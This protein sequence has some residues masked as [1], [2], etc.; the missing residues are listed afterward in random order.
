MPWLQG[1][2]DVPAS[3]APADDA[4]ARKKAAQL[5]QRASR[6]YLEHR[7]AEAAE[8]LR[9]CLEIEPRQPRVVK[10]LGLCYQ[11][12]NQ[13]DQARE[14]FLE[15]CKLAPA[16]SEAWFFLARI[17]WVENFFDKALGALK[18]ALRLNPRDYRIHELLALT[19]E[20]EGH[21]EQ[22]LSAYREAVKWN[23][24]SRNPSP[25]PHL[26]YGCFLYKLDRLE[27]SEEQL[28]RSRGLDPKDWRVHFEL[29][30]LYHRLAKYDEAIVDLT[31]ALAAGTANK[32]ESVRVY[33]VLAQVYG[34][35]GRHAEA[36]S[37][38]ALSEKLKP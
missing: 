4:E 29:G 16:D 13:T 22:A 20:A 19:L 25:T 35:M 26:N 5:Y 34:R 23:A 6:L 2:L 28:R 30:K 36:Q 24:Q 15:A 3:A 14:A 38:I 9:R 33:R 10:L 1:R 32:D 21:M 11:L 18:T 12:V 27:E 8:Q 31:Q 37:A 7:F 17:Y